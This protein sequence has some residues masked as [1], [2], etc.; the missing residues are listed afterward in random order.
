METL[1]EIVKWNLG[2]HDKFVVKLYDRL[3]DGNEHGRVK[4]CVLTAFPN[5]EYESK[6]SYLQDDAVLKHFDKLKVEYKYV[7]EDI[8]FRVDIQK[9]YKSGRDNEHARS[10]FFVNTLEHE[11][12]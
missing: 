6:I 3:E 9:E 7:K 2:V 10:T 11:P 4:Y 5:G 1:L 12:K 8:R